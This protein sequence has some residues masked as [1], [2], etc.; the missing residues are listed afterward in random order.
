M[1][2][3]ELAER[4]VAAT[5]GEALAVVT[6]E[7]W[8]ILRFARSRPTQATSVD[9]VT[10]Q[11]AVVRDGHVGRGSTNRSDLGSLRDCA[12]GATQ[13][14]T[15]ASRMSGPGTFPGFPEPAQPRPHEGYDR[16][17]AV[18]DTATG[19][20][21][22]RT[23]F[24]TAADAGVEVGGIWTT[25]EV[26]TGVASSGGASVQDR[27]TDAY[28]KVVAFAGAKRSGYASTAAVSARAID[29]RALTA[30]AA[31]KATSA[32][33][34]FALEPG[35]YTVVFERHAVS[36]LLWVLSRVAFNGMVHAEGRGA[37]SGKLGARVAAP[38]INISDSPRYPGTLPRAFDSEGVPKTSLPLIKDGV[39]HAVAH[40]TRSAAIAGTQT[41]GHALAPGGAVRG[42]IPSNLVLLGGGKGDEAS[43]CSGVERGI[44][45]T[46]LWYTNPVRTENSLFTAVTRDGTFLIENGRPTSPVADMRVTDTALGI[47][48]RTRALGARPELTSD[49][50]FYGRRFATGSV[51]PPLLAEGVSLTGSAGA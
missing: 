34:P 37:L 29:A 1:N 21:V 39:A 16:A 8:V 3:Q 13:R 11:L 32:G 19:G 17:T 25:G 31:G 40:D 48:E 28:M 2:V 12:D 41:T 43:L 7:R 26:E 47:L 50:E 15:A 30:R 18:A 22:L 4:T 20:A 51:C 33:E 6:R 9:D 42:P 46:R 44:Y 5:E 14:A 10:V 27:V 24:D 49:G 23:A 38:A 45:V 35:E 36:E